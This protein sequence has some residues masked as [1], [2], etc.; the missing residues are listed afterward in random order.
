MIYTKI[1]D[2]IFF[3]DNFDVNLFNSLCVDRFVS[4]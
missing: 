2:M 3:L 4:S 1:F